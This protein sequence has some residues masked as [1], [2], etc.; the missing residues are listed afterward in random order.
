M[1]LAGYDGDVLGCGMMMRRPLGVGGRFQPHDKRAVLG[2]IARLH[3]QLHAFRQSRRRRAPFGI[4]PL[5][6]SG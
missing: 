4:G 2:R 6:T 5:S 3:G 1:E